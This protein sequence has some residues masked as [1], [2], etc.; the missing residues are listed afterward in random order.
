LI[1]DTSALIAILNKEPDALRLAE[2]IGD[3]DTPIVISA[4]TLMEATMVA[5]G[6]GGAALGLELDGLLRRV[7]ARVIAVDARQAD[8]ARDGWRR[9]GKGRHPA[10]LN[11]G[12]CFSYALARERGEPLLFKGDDFAQTDVK[13]AI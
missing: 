5:E 1:L 7:G 10:K 6:R 9:F 2:A 11:L 3:S 12:D 4:A 8:L 13:R